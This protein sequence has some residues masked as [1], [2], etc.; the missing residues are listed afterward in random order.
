MFMILHGSNIYKWFT[1]IEEL[2][3]NFSHA[4]EM[5]SAFQC[6]NIFTYP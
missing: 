1:N 6:K 4:I 2:K 5:G 3:S